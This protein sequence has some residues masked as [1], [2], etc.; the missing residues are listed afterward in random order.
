MKNLEITHEFLNKHYW[1]EVNNVD[2][3]NIGDYNILG[4]SPNKYDLLSDA[5]N[6]EFCD[7]PIFGVPSNYKKITI[8]NVETCFRPVEGGGIH[9]WLSYKDYSND[10]RFEK[11]FMLHINTE[12]LYY[13]LSD[14]LM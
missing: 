10:S 7:N 8:V 14:F 13:E 1:V 12:N 3:F 9:S 5:K 6:I 4:E 11:Y 2:C